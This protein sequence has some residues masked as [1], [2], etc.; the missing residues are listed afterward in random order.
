MAKLKFFDCNCSIGRIAYPLLYDIHDVDG[1]INEMDVAGIEEALVYH[2][3]ARDGQ[4]KSRQN[5][6]NC[7]LLEEHV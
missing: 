7:S 3:L 6:R 4:K 2:A 1:L 5:A